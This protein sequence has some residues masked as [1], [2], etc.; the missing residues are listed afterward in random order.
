MAK[1]FSDAEKKLLSLCKSGEVFEYK[2]ENYIIEFSDK[3]TVPKGEPKTD[4]FIGV[5]NQITGQPL[6]IKISYK[7][8]NAE[9]LENKIKAERAQQLLGSQWKEILRYSIKNIDDLL[10]KTPL[11]YKKK[12]HPTREGSITLGWKFEIL[13][14]AN[15]KLSGKL[16]ISKEK[17]A[18]VIRDVYSGTN[19]PEEKRHAFIC[20]KQIENSGIANNILWGDIKDS[21]TLS[22]VIK[23]LIPVEQFIKDH[24]NIYFACTGCNYRLLE[25]KCDGRRP[26]L[27]HVNWT[28]KDG[29]L[30]SSL[31]FDNPLGAVATDVMD[32]LKICLNELNITSPN[33]F[34]D[35]K[36]YNSNIIY[37]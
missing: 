26:L 16:L 27:I 2:G 18:H 12:K 23:R 28:I 30:N 5:K 21:D 32:K 24:P 6:A 4:V 7:K 19:L 25:D 34:N 36:I 33:D 10:E 31:V 11:M 15:R 14:V 17:A 9:F 35:S 3:P 37:E 20:G 1:K 8:E 29:K 22:D 13:T